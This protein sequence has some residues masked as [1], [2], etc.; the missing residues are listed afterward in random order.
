MKNLA[1]LMVVMIGLSSC[2]KVSRILPILGEREVV[3]G[4]TIYHSIPDFSFVNQDS[5][6]VTNATFAGK[7]Y[8]ADFFFISC[9]TICPKTAK[10]MLRIYEH[11][12]NDDRI[13]RNTTQWRD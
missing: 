1:V 11:F 4:D 12:E 10:Q 6:L 9:P 13:M 5:Q 3:D 7:V 8:V 2:E